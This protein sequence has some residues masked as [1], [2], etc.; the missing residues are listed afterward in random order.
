MGFSSF[1]ICKYTGPTLGT[2]ESG[3]L[4]SCLLEQVRNVRKYFKNLMFKLIILSIT[5]IVN[6]KNC[7]WRV[8]QYSCFS[9]ISKCFIQDLIL[10]IFFNQGSWKLIHGFFVLS[11]YLVITF[12]RNSISFIRNIYWLWDINAL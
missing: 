12:S 8:I 3:F 1:L 9:P 2:K 7:Q 10:N 11:I 6:E 5:V 4:K